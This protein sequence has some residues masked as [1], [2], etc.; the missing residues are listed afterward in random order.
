MHIRLF[1]LMYVFYCLK[2]FVYIKV[3]MFVYISSLF[4]WPCNG[5][6]SVSWLSRTKLVSVITREVM[7]WEKL[8]KVI[9]RL[10]RAAILGFKT[11]TWKFC[12]LS[13]SELT[14]WRLRGS[15]YVVANKTI[16]YDLKQY[17]LNRY[18]IH[19][20]NQLII[21]DWYDAEVYHTNLTYIQCYA[22]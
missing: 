17:G 4:T 7:P 22:I 14:A 3:R 10:G 5:T 19:K 12:D 2:Y 16:V 6:A 11:F 1:L 15:P 20:P 9:L 21:H 8:F 18:F 13:F